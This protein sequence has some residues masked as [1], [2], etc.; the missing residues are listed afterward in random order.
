MDDYIKRKDVMDKCGWYNLIGGKHS[1][2][3]AQAWKIASVPAADVTEVIRC[4]ECIHFN[5]TSLG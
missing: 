4:G 5:G 3:A 1:I 2:H